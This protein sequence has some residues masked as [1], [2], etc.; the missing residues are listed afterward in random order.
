MKNLDRLSKKAAEFCE[1]SGYDVDKVKEAM[2]SGSFA[3]QKCETKSEMED[4]GFDFSFPYVIW[5]PYN[6][7]IE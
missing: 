6:L 4:E 7:D 5:N 3:V 1:M 2:K